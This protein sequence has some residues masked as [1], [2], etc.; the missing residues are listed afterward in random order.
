MDTDRNIST[1]EQPLPSRTTTEK[2]R[3]DRVCCESARS[4]GGLATFSGGIHEEIIENH[5]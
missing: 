2:A 5:R 3:L 1:Q 4:K